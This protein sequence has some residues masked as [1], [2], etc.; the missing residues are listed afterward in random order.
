MRSHEEYVPLSMSSLN[1]SEDMYLT[2]RGPQ[3]LLCLNNN[4]WDSYPDVILCM[5]CILLS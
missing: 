5:L 1:Y 2:C 4:V 3:L